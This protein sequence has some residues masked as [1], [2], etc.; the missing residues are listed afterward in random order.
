MKL[1]CARASRDET[2]TEAVELFVTLCCCVA[3]LRD[4]RR[5]GRMGHEYLSARPRKVSRCSI[6]LLLTAVHVHVGL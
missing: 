4:F 3:L 1:F 2:R 5:A 6:S